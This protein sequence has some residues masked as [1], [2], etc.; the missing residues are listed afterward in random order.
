M[1]EGVTARRPV[2]ALTDLN[3]PFWTSGADGVLRM[4]KCASCARFVHPPALVCPHDHGELTYVELSGR[5][6]VESWTRNDHAWFPWMPSSYVVAFVN[7]VEDNRVRL[8]TNV[9]DVDPDDL[10]E[11]LPVA[12]RFDR[13]EA[14]G[15]VVFVPVF[16]PAP[17]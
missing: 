3:R 9:V 17:A 15:D 5:G 12:V 10:A 7:P 16:A 13:V 11:G 2:P 1:N 6:V 8:L 14:D 4:Q